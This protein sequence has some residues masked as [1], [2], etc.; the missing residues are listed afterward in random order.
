M[1]TYNDHERNTYSRSSPVPPTSTIKGGEAGVARPDPKTT[2]P[3]NN[4]E[5]VSNLFVDLEA[6]DVVAV[7]TK[8]GDPTTGPW[9]AV[10]A[11]E[12]GRK[13]PPC[14]NNYYCTA[15]LKPT[16][17]GALRATVDQAIGYR[18]LM[19][20]DVGTKGDIEALNGIVPT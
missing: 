3:R 7:C 18:I 16:A 2:H 6:N 20:D 12:I 14:N 9:H 1:T 10:D 8:V 11:A 17:D 4:A 13:C 5:F 15:T 19:A